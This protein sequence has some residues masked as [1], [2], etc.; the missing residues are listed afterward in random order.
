MNLK[1]Y[2]CDDDNNVVNKTLK[3][4][5]DQ[6]I[7]LLDSTSKENPKITIRKNESIEFAIANYNYAFLDSPFNRHYYITDV[8]SVSG[9]TWELQ[10]SVDVL[11]SFKD[12]I[13][14]QNAVIERSS[15]YFNTYITDDSYVVQNRTR[16][17]T[18]V[19]P[20]GFNS[21]G[22]ILVCAG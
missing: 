11:M 9:H 20:S 2:Y 22:L 10:L 12:E 8:K 3:N 7:V 19:F 4:E 16:T 6:T 1:L 17:Q 14:K 21:D 15:K 18:K 5:V 13:L